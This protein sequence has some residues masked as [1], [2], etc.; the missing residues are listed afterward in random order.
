MNP[1]D[2]YTLERSEHCNNCGEDIVDLSKYPRLDARFF[3]G[4]AETDSEICCSCFFVAMLYR[5]C[6]MGFWN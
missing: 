6:C 2:I 1:N 4:F 3:F 5:M